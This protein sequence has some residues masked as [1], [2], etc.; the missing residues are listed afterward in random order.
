MVQDN[1]NPLHLDVVDRYLGD[2]TIPDEALPSLESF[3]PHESQVSIYHNQGVVDSFSRSS[4]KRIF[5]HKI[6]SMLQSFCHVH[7]NT[8]VGQSCTC[9]YGNAHD[10]FTVA[11]NSVYHI[12]RLQS[13]Q[14]ENISIT[15][16][17]VSI[18]NILMSCTFC[19]MHLYAHKS[20]LNVRDKKVT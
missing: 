12:P 14:Y 7:P 3:Y 16:V 9:P 8:E 2:K 13:C 11:P 1:K 18:Y 17:Q 4:I 19:C 5:W 10:G 20:W 15:I 6:I